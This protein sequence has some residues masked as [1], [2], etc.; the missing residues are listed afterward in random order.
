M[1]ETVAVWIHPLLGMIALLW[2]FVTRKALM[3]P[4]TKRQRHWRVIAPLW[5]IIA[6]TSQIIFVLRGF[7]ETQDMTGIPANFFGILSCLGALVLYIAYVRRWLADDDMAAS[8]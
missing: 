1:W 3:N 7:S 8:S 4:T 2:V 6:A 5:I